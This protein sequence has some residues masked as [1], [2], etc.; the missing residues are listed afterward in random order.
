MACESSVD[1]GKIVIT[2]TGFPVELK[3][4]TRVSALPLPLPPAKLKH[5]SNTC[6][7]FNLSD[8]KA[9]IA[10]ILASAASWPI[11]RFLALPPIP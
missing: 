4:S 11:F 8:T 6:A 9:L 5:N 1:I 3:T 7:L 2:T 10:S